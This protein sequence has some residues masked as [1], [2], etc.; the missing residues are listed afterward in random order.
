MSGEGRVQGME[1][2]D[3]CSPQAAKPL[4]PSLGVTQI[5]GSLLL[6][7]LHRKPGLWLDISWWRGRGGLMF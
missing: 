5:R 4:D 3:M 6:Q 7:V 2:V 1:E